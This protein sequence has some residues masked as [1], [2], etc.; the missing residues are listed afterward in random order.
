MTRSLEF[1]PEEKDKYE[2]FIMLFDLGGNILHF[3]PQQGQTTRSR[4]ER[5]KEAKIIRAYTSIEGNGKF[6]GG[7]IVLEQNVYELLIRYL[8]AAPAPTKQ[9]VEIDELLDWANAAE[10]DKGD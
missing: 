6:A 1:K 3:N 2:L 4:D 9:S 8:E 7:R 10:K 5:K